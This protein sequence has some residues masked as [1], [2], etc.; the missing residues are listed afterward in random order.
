MSNS[1]NGARALVLGLALSVSGAA[2]AQAACPTGLPPGVTCGVPSTADVTSGT[3]A[4]DPGHAAVIARVS[5]IGY[6]I[7]VFRFDKVAGSLT[8]DQADPAKSKLTATVETASIA[9]NVAGFATELAGDSY[10]KSKAFPQATFT[11][12]AFRP[13]D[14]THGK[15]DGQLSLMGKTQPV[16][17]DVTLVGGGKGFGHPRMG[18]EAKTKIMPADFGMSPFF[19]DPIELVLDVELEKKS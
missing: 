15:V 6:S 14:A 17:F 7:S 16:T 10:L 8:W 13:T 11:S 5:H 9:T 2:L 3:Y 18:V 12:T 4:V 1:L 19:L